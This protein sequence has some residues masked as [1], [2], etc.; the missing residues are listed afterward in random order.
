MGVGYAF[1]FRRSQDQDELEELIG[2]IADYIIFESR[3]ALQ[4]TSEI[5]HKSHDTTFWLQIRGLQPDQR[6][7]TSSSILSDS[8]VSSLT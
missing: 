6:D 1:R 7:A 2:A 3:N 4:L 5:V 8:A